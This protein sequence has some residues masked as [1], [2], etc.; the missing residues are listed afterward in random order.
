M[1]FLFWEP[2]KCT[3]KLEIRKNFVLDATVLC[4]CVELVL[5]KFNYQALSFH[6]LCLSYFLSLCRIYCGVI[7]GKFINIWQNMVLWIKHHY[8]IQG[9]G[10]CYQKSHVEMTL[11]SV[12]SDGTRMWVKV[13]N[14]DCVIHCCRVALRREFKFLVFIK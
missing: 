14:C 12:V 4:F 1:T 6:N 10:N 7:S 13:P 11:D 5:S 9:T 3:T 8:T 2:A